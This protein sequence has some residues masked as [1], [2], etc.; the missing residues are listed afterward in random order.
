M[1]IGEKLSP[2]EWVA[3]LCLTIVFVYGE[4]IRAIER[5]WVP[6]FVE[7]AREVRHAQSPLV[8]LLAP[9]YGLSLIAASRGELVRA[10]GGVAAIAGL[11]VLVQRFPHPWRGITDFAVAAA[12]LWGL[13]A[14]LRRA[15][16]VCGK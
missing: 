7:R 12:L 13:A 10:W 1:T 5:R 9:L 6:H 14:I 15:P 11:V 16:E 2:A 8:R 3:L 4:G